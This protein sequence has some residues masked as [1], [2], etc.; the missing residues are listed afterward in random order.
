MTILSTVK[1]NRS[2]I[3]VYSPKEII[4]W[5]TFVAYFNLFPLHL[6]FVVLSTQYTSTNVG[7]ENWKHRGL[8]GICAHSFIQKTDVEFLLCRI[9]FSWIHC[10]SKT[11]Q[12]PQ[13]AK[14]ESMDPLWRKGRYE[15]NGG[16][17]RLLINLLDVCILTIPG[18][19]RLSS[20]PLSTGESSC[21]T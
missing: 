2:E 9:W 13:K 19:S 15:Q 12:N 4:R 5:K 17:I 6:Y 20:L 8:G 11:K 16:D 14:N 1:W 7:I 21:L 10:N 18:W 3:P